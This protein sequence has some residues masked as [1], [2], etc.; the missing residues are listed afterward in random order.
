MCSA[1]FQY[2]GESRSS[3]EGDGYGPEYR[4]ICAK[5]LVLFTSELLISGLQVYIMHSYI[6]H[7]APK[8]KE[9]LVSVTLRNY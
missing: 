2:L 1:G 3:D 5:L 4:F 9:K 8:K 6:V 7:E